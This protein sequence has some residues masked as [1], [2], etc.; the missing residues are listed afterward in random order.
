MGFHRF[1]SVA[2]LGAPRGGGKGKGLFVYVRDSVSCRL[3]AESDVCMWVCIRSP[4]PASPPLYLGAVYLP[5][6]ASPSWAEGG[7]SLSLEGLRDQILQFQSDGRVLLLGDFNAHVGPLS[8]THPEADILLANLPEA[9]ALPSRWGVPAARETPPGA[10]T[11]ALGRALVD[12]ICLSTGCVLLNGRAPSAAPGAGWTFQRGLHC[13]CIDYGIIDA[14]AYTC[15]SD[16]SIIPEQGDRHSDHLGL[17]C[18]LQFSPPAD[19]HEPAPARAARPNLRWDPRKR[20]EYVAALESPS[21]QAQLQ[22]L[23]NLDADAAARRFEEIIYSTAEAVFGVHAPRRRSDGGRG[24]PPWFRGCRRGWWCLQDARHSGSLEDQAQAKRLFRQTVRR[25]K[26]RYEAR[27]QLPLLDSLRRS[28]RRFWSMYK[29]EASAGGGFTMAELQRHWQSV[30]AGSGR[31]ALSERAPGGVPELIAGLA[32]RSAAGRLSAALRRDADA[33]NAPFSVGHVQAAM[34]RMRAGAVA[35]LDGIGACHLKEAWHLL[36]AGEHKVREYILPNHITTVVNKVFSGRYPSHWGEVPIS[37]IFKKGDQ[38]DLDNYRPIAVNSI[39]AKIA[40]ELIRSRLDDF[41]EKHGFRAE[42]QA[43]FR[44]GRRTSDHVFLLKH[45]IDRHRLHSRA[46]MFCCFVDFQKAYDSV[47]RGLLLDRLADMGLSGN[48]LRTIADMYYHARLTPRLGPTLG[49]PFHS[50]CGVRQGD[51]LSP[52]LFGVFIDQFEAFAAERAPQVGVTLGAAF[53]GELLRVLLYADDMVLMASDS[54]GL[55]R[56][57]EVLEEFCATYNMRVNID[58]T[59]VVVFGRKAYQPTEGQAE[60]T[61][62]GAPLRVSPEFKYLGIILH[63]T[64]GM[65]PAISHL[66]A[67][68]LR[69]TWA[70]HSRCKRLGIRDISMR[71]R[72]FRILAEPIMCYCSEVWGPGLLPSLD[73]ALHSDLQVVANDYI[74]HLGGLRRSVP[75]DILSRECCVQPLGRSWLRAALDLWNR[76]LDA[77][78]TSIMRRALLADLAITRDAGAPVG[79]ARGP[80]GRKEALAAAIAEPDGRRAK[81]TR[82]TWSGSFLRTLS[83]LSHQGGDASNAVGAHL[84]SVLNIVFPADPA[85]VSAGLDALRGTLTREAALGAWDAAMTNRW[86]TA[87]AQPDGPVAEYAAGPALRAAD[88]EQED[89]FPAEMPFYIRHTSLFNPDHA[90]ALMRARCCSSDNSACST[91]TPSAG[92]PLCPHCIPASRRLEHGVQVP[93]E[94]LHHVLLSCPHYQQLR[95]NPA[96]A[97]LFTPT[98]QASLTAFLN[99]QSRQVLLA[100]FISR[101]FATRAETPLRLLWAPTDEVPDHPTARTLARSGCTFYSIVVV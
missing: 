101:C 52:L 98:T 83:W 24:E 60:W 73:G 35:G 19:A 25:E 32:E 49:A 97:R 30:L 78:N 31:G 28:P 72:L 41:C 89:G 47:D 53:G 92:P 13:S 93:R 9:V 88:Y 77:P 14:R 26:R 69:A 50:T 82:A 6:A 81:A 65:S 45:L 95:E 10:R 100:S 57:L 46:R 17:S 87:V 8:D 71:L 15:V 99:Q 58:K 70:M 22:A 12:T 20:A 91:T 61:H 21:T 18:T 51:P 90:R 23:E 68:A 56:L 67:A 2:H 66:K 38:G 40:S 33:L 85:N 16:F 5:P 11:D 94:D 84:A 39:L 43:G 86:N 79:A 27:G 59:E 75:F 7:P 36:G 3:V 76:A 54:A 4:W 63:S 1:G 96:Y 29:E 37:A 34:I 64:R 62:R 48:M 44:P 42:G 80:G 74:R 55:Q